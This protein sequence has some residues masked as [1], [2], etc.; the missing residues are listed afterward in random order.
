VILKDNI[1]FQGYEHFT[2]NGLHGVLAFYRFY[3]MGYVD[4][5][6]LGISCVPLAFSPEA[7]YTDV[8]P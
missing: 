1:Y 3:I 4:N 7:T 5:G 6:P 2:I 8:V